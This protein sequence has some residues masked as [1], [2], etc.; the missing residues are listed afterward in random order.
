MLLALAGCGSSDAEPGVD[1]ADKRGAAI[2]CL[3]AKGCRRTRTAGTRTRSCPATGPRVE[4]L[5][6]RGQAEAAQFE[7]EGEG[8]EQI[9]SAL[10]FV[11]PEVRRETEDCLEAR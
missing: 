7:G 5:P 9:G 4:V 11:E 8:A 3:D 1:E 10:L 2:A 6:H